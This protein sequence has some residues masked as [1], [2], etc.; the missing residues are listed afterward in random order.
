MEMNGYDKEE[1]LRFILSR[2]NAKEH[3]ELADGIERFIRQAIDADI[4]FMHQT[5]VL[6]EDGNAGGEYYEDDDAFE[7]MVEDL[8]AKNDLTPEQ[9]VK[10]ASLIDDFMDF[11]QEYMEYKGL[12][13]EGD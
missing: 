8:V 7:Y 6:D 9:A 2:I 12:V 1:A 5:G 13:D 3:R 4:A 11:Q 10:V